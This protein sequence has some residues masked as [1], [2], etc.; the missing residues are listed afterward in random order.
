[1]Y[2]QG[3]RRTAIIVFGCKRRK[4]EVYRHVPLVLCRGVGSIANRT[5][6]RRLVRCRNTL[7]QS[8]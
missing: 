5:K 3:E 4:D 8:R 2:I 1:M 6:A 7:V